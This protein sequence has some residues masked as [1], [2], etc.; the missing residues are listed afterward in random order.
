MQVAD[1]GVFGPEGEFPS[2]VTATAMI[3][4]VPVGTFTL[5]GSFGNQLAVDTT[6]S[7]AVSLASE[8]TLTATVTTSAATSAQAIFP[9]YITTSTQQLAVN[10]VAYFNSLPIKLPRMY[11]PPHQSQ[12]SGAL[13]Q[14]VFQQVAG[15]ESTSLQ[16]SLLAVALPTTPG[17]D[18]EIYD[19]AVKAALDA[20]RTQLLSGV[21]QI[22]A[23]KLPV[24]PINA[25]TTSSSTSTAGTSS[26]STGGGTGSITA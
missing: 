7:S 18:L 5:T 19:A 1:A 22:F 13:Q 23:G 6:Q 17:A 2:P 12:R 15:P 26:S 4:A 3:G 20:S 21:Q 11:A 8:T 16:K 14:Y 25:S 24:I 10:L 9:N